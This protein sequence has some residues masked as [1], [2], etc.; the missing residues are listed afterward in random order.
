MTTKTEA[1]ESQT[2]KTGWMLYG[3]TGYTGRRVAREAIINGD[4][5]KEI[6]GVPLANDDDVSYGDITLT[7][8]LT[9]SVNTAFASALC[10]L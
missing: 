3:A 1:N 10:R 2:K 4:S 8:A 5:P 7:T 9:H 6:S